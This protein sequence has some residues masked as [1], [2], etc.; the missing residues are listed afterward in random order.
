LPAVGAVFAL[1]SA[2]WVAAAM[3]VN[4]ALA[5][6][7]AS[8]LGSQSTSIGILLGWNL[9]ASHLLVQVGAL[10]DAR[11]WLPLSALDR[12]EPHTE[13]LFG[14]LPIGVA[15]AALVLWPLVWGAAGMWRTVR[16]DV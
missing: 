12:L 9:A 11:W 15:V 1:T 7:V 16:A 4:G 13:P 2:A 10:G 8:L 3:A 14:A 6:G 5:V